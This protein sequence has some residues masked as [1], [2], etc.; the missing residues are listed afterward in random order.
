MNH[1]TTRVLAILELLQK[2][3]RVSGAELARSIEV[4]RRTVR[5]YIA[6]LEDLGI[7]ITTDRCPHGVYY[8]VASYKIPPL[9]VNNDE[10]LGF[11]LGVGS[12]KVLGFATH[13]VLADPTAL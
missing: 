7:P 4:D 8:L 13:E 2:H 3:G 5:R 12:A 10:P 6:V 9:M 11:A 1:P